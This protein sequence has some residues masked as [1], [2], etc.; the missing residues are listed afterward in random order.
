[1]ETKKQMK[2]T[3][4][5]LAMNEEWKAWQEIFD[6][7]CKV[8]NTTREELNKEEYTP[9]FDKIRNWANLEDTLFHRVT[10]NI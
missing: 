5:N 1:M 3:E 6:E 4:Q 10:K 9:L 8:F 7:M 2:T